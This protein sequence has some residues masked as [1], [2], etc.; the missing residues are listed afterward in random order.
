M[1]IKVI[2]V[3]KLSQK[4]W[5][6]ASD[7]YL[8]YLRPYHQ[9]TLQEVPDEP[10][11][12]QASPGAIAQ[13]LSKEGDRILRA[14]PSA[15]PIICLDVLGKSLTTEAMAKALKDFETKGQSQVTFV[16]GGSYG[17][18]PRVKEKA[19]AL[20]SLSALTFPHQMARILLLEQIFRCTKINLGQTYHK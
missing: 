10:D 11:P 3:G 19:H 8:K 6:E 4:H 17:I 7:T 13:V 1:Y 5:Q 16:I 9:V 2:G 12:K 15:G 14:L 18:D 20:W